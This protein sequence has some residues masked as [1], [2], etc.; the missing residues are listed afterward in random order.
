[1]INSWRYY[2]LEEGWAHKAG[3]R[4]SYSDIHSHTLG[5]HEI[6][7]SEK[8]WG[9]MQT[10]RPHPMP[11]LLYGLT[12]GKLLP[13]H[14]APEPHLRKRICIEKFSWIP[15]MFWAIIGV[16]LDMILMWIVSGVGCFWILNQ[17]ITKTIII[18]NMNIFH[19]TDLEFA[20]CFKMLDLW[21]TMCLNLKKCIIW[22]LWCLRDFYVSKQQ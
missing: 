18:I 7:A 4:I 2:G 14:R 17:Q 1:M 5:F 21:C 19:F 9:K 16:Q 8:Q 13:P 12:P 20:L 6:D 15:F 10:I 22:Y 3:C 11:A